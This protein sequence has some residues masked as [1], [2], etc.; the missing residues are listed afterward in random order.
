MRLAALRMTVS[1]REQ[2]NEFHVFWKKK[3]EGLVNFLLGL[4]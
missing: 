1:L 3:L 2:A 4:E